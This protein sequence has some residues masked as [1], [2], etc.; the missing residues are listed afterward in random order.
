MFFESAKSGRENE[1]KIERNFC[2]MRIKG[3]FCGINKSI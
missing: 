1:E 3:Y 2:F